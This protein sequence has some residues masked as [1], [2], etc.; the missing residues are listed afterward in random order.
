MNLEHFEGK[1]LET[2]AKING[3]SVIFRVWAG[4][5]GLAGGIRGGGGVLVR[6][7]SARVE[8]WRSHNHPHFY[9]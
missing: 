2:E 9:P 3:F 5:M 7:G 4:E 1:I 8:F 6:V